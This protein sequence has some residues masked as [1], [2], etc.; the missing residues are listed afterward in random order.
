MTIPDL[1]MSLRT[2]AEDREWQKF[3][4]P[5]NLVMAM[6]GEVGEVAEL[7]QWLTEDES[8]A[9][10]DSERTAARVREELADVLAY[11]LRIA[12]VL[13]IDL[14][15]ALEAKIRVNGEKYPV[16]LSRGSAAKYTDLHSG[17]RS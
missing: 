11:L 8:R 4:S 6:S 7:F 5:K 10:M 1:T 15:E 3:H 2:F 14:A 9:I 13:G 16:E 17:G 12:D